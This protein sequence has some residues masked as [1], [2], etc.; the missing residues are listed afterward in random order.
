[1][2]ATALNSAAELVA[3]PQGSGAMLHLQ[4]VGG[5][6][7]AAAT[8]WGDRDAYL[9]GEQRLTYAQLFENAIDWARAL[10]GLGVGPG[11]HVG[12]LMPNSVEYLLLFHAATMIG[13]RAV[14]INARYRDDD[15]LYV[16]DNADVGFLFIG[17][18]ALPHTDYRA[19]LARVYPE[20]A[21]WRKCEP[22]QLA[23]APKLRSIVNLADPREDA[24]PQE[25]D[26]LAGANS[27]SRGDAL[28]C[29]AS[30]GPGDTCIMMF[31]SGTTSR[32]KACMLSHLNISLAGQA[33]AKRFRMSERDRIFNPMPFF[34]MSTMLPL[35]ACRASGA[36]FLGQMHFNAGLALE[37]IECE[38]VTIS[39]T[40][41]P[42]I[43]SAMTD[44][45]DFPRR[46]LS[47]LRVL[48]SVGPADLLRR[49]VRAFPG[50][51]IVNAYGLTEAT[52][53]PVWSD[54]DDP[55]DL[56]LVTS[57]K[58]FEGLDVKAFDIE[59][60][61]ILPPGENG[62]LWIRGWSLFQG[63]YRDEKRT[64][65]A[66]TGDGWLRTG[67]IGSVD[68]SGRVSYAGRLKD[69][70]KIGGENVAAI[71]IENY[72]CTHPAVQIAQV[73]AVP[74]EHLFEVA[75]AFIELRPGAAATA[76]EI[77]RHCV[78]KIASFKIPR[79]I[80][81]VSEWPMSAT[82]IQKF[83]LAQDFRPDGKIDVR[84]LVAPEQR[85]S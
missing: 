78:G 32:P 63:Y 66:L 37:T 79:Y 39:Y 15:L 76:E 28:T 24:W 56:S 59:T 43:N 20:L 1:M 38:R 55:Q 67:D 17:G 42:T 82:K 58:P 85:A 34:H 11:D 48:H 83:R 47:S 23:A 50:T 81:F 51:Y 71:E 57:G 49:Y 69:M 12:L 46:D 61:A 26:F 73:I 70:L 22:L 5:A 44:H 25:A 62:E 14:T 84:A 31:S 35:A 52:G 4:T 16:I 68:E 60:H 21:E 33:L 10:I 18:Q 53:V 77:A 29:A 8:R 74:D 54:L 6:L 27:V 75:A 80:S 65:E 40:S 3:A 36:A 41:F 2:G 7:A 19:M 72:L 45:A 30:V 9:I 64:A 13:A